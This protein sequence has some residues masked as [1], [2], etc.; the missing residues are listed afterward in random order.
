MRKILNCI[1]L[2]AFIFHQIAWA[3]PLDWKPDFESASVLPYYID[4]QNRHWV[5]LSKKTYPDK[6]YG[7]KPSWGDF[8]GKVET[9][10]R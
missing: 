3:V 6:D 5:L 1:V 2:F 7:Q 4:N 8:G 10:E 9:G